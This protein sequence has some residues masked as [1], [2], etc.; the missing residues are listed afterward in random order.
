MPG[1][2]DK[3]FTH[4]KPLKEGSRFTGSVR[5][6]NLTKA[7]LGLLLW[8]ICLEDD[9][10][11]NIGMGKSLGYG[12]IGLEDVTLKIFDTE[13]A[14][15]LNQTLDWQPMMTG[16]IKTYIDVYKSEIN[17][18]LRGKDIDSLSSIQAFFKMHDRNLIP[19]NHVTDICP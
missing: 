14:Y 5:F 1:K 8:S 17:G 15:D 2:N 9:C 10:L 13:K 19:G 16:D 3:V 6:R 4:M 7:E 12:V 11:M 18:K